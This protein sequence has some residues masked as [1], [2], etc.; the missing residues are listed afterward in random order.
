MGEVVGRRERVYDVGEDPLEEA[1]SQVP[2]HL[3][4]RKE[5]LDIAS[6]IS[7]ERAA[8]KLPPLYD[9][10][11]FSDDEHLVC[12]LLFVSMFSRRSLNGQAELAERPSFPNLSPQGKYEDLH[13]NTTLGIIPAPIAQ[14]LR[15]YQVKGTQFLHE[16]FVYQRGGILGDDMGLGKTVQVIAFLT[17]AFGKTGDERDKKRMRKIRRLGDLDDVWYPRVLIVCPGTL[18]DNWKSELDTVC[19]IYEQTILQYTD[20]WGG[21]GAG[22]SMMFTTGAKMTRRAH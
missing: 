8:L 1:L 13:M 11:D 16:C 20:S 9:D 21:S 14:W 4:K 19:N 3:K 17:A 10:V 2:E 5:V 7:D 6:K 22:G 15:D 18:M 12:I